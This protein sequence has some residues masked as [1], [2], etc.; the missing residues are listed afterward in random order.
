MVESHLAL[1]HMVKT[2]CSS[3]QSISSLDASARLVLLFSSSNSRA[4]LYYLGM[5]YP[6][7]YLFDL[8]ACLILDCM[9]ALVKVLSLF[10]RFLNLFLPSII[11]LGISGTCDWII[12]VSQSTRTLYLHPFQL[13]SVALRGPWWPIS[14]LN[15]NRSSLISSSS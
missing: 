11:L 5:R 7:M 2:S 14:A 13:G 8:L 9:T 10:A 3:M 15:L 1:W 6:N 12:S 4:S